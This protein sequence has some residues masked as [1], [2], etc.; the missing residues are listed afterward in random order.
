MG[1]LVE[2]LNRVS[3]EN[4]KLTEMLTVMCESYN[5]LRSQVV[6]YM[7]KNCEK[8]LSPPRKR[9]SESSNVNNDDNNN[10]NIATNGQSESSST[11]EDS[12]S[13]KKP[14][15]EII[16]A[17]ISKVY[18]RTEANDTSLVIIL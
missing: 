18:M 2:E 12:S 7:S 17:K 9:K 10:N 8:E 6:D 16:K 1:S 5:A 4:K 14:R 15:E 11:D 3:A 13:N